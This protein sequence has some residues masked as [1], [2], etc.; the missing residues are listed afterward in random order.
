MP[1]P[2]VRPRGPPE[3]PRFRW[4]HRRERVPRPG[5]PNPR[6]RQSRR[7]ESAVLR[8]PPRAGQ[9]THRCR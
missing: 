2:P 5:W 6:P 4:R 1:R 3:S 7:S 9:P 8:R